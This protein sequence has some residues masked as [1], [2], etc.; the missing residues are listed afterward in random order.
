MSS[1]YNDRLFGSPVSKFA[2][3]GRT[4]MISLAVAIDLGNHSLKMEDDEAMSAAKAPEPVAKVP[5]E[6]ATLQPDGRKYPTDA[7]VTPVLLTQREDTALKSKD[8]AREETA[9]VIRDSAVIVKEQELAEQVNALADNVVKN[10]IDT[11]TSQYQQDI[12]N[13]IL[14][15]RAKMAGDGTRDDLERAKSCSELGD[16]D[17]FEDLYV[18]PV[19]DPYNKAI[20]YLEKHN[21]LQLF[22]GLT[23]NVIYSRPADPLEAMMEQLQIMKKNQISSPSMTPSEQ[24]IGKMDS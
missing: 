24:A 1:Q 6:N 9:E 4:A 14:S 7:T 3:M 11:V 13:S 17:V 22:Q 12:L 10:T 19:P 20:S 8:F 18:E 23:A 15:A 16:D 2:H 5:A 21:I